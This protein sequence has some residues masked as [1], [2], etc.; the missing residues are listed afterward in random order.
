LEVGQVLA[1]V[2]RIK[3]DQTFGEELVTELRKVT[4]DKTLGES[5]AIIPKESHKAEDLQRN[6]ENK[7]AYSCS[8][9]PVW[10]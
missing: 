6:K 8:P 1:D 4:G 10:V 7:S 2:R 3:G 9:K 5:R